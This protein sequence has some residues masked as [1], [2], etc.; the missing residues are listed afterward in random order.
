MHFLFP[1]DSLDPRSP[2]DIFVEQLAA[3]NEV[4]FSTSL[5]P[6]EVLV[7]GKRLKGIPQNGQ[8]IYRGWMLTADE[9]GRLAEAIEAAGG[10]PYISPEEYLAGHHLPRWYQL[11]PDLTPETRIYPIETDLVTA[12][13]DLGW[14]AFFVKDY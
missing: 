5:L 8:V 14:D 4:G 2:D 11:I 3:L 13:K 7:E 12:L 6:E 1:S 10:V 9:Y